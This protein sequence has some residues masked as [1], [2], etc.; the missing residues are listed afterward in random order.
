MIYRHRHSHV[1]GG[2]LHQTPGRSC[3]WHSGVVERC[4]DTAAITRSPHKHLMGTDAV[5]QAGV[6]TQTRSPSRPAQVAPCIDRCSSTTAAKMWM[7]I[8]LMPDGIRVGSSFW[9]E[10]SFAETDRLCVLCLENERLF[11]GLDNVRTKF[12]VL[13]SIAAGLSHRSGYATNRTA[14]AISCAGPA[15]PMTLL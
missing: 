10:R 5:H 3:C 9:L 2:K 12:A 7:T 13:R 11:F 15:P 1:Q 8:R 14:N 6:S 4:A